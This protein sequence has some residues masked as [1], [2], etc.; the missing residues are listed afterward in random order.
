M[1]ILIAPDSFK[2]CMSALDAAHAMAV[3]AR[4]AGEALGVNIDIDI[5]PVSD[6]GEGFA[7]AL[8]HASEGELLTLE[9]AGPT[10]EPVE[11]RWGV[12]GARRISQPGGIADTVID[13]LSGIFMPVPFPLGRDDEHRQDAIMRPV[14][15]IEAAQV[16]GLH[17]VPIAEREPEWATTL[18][19]GELIAAALD[20][21][22]RRLII[23]LG[24]SATCDGG[25][26]MAAALGAV[27]RDEQSKM[28][29][30]PTGAHLN[31]IAEIDVRRLD[32][33]L[34]E[35]EIIAAC[36]VRNPL[37]GP[38]GA[39]PVYAPQ[40]GADPAQVARLN[41]GLA[42]LARR[43]GETG[44]PSDSAF[45]GAGAAGGLGFGVVSF[46]GA[47]KGAGAEIAIHLLGLRDRA[48][49]AS[50]VLTGEGRL[51]AQS[52]EGKAAI[53][54]AREARQAGTDA[55]ALVGALG[56]GAERAEAAAGGPFTRIIPISPP[57]MPTEEAIR[58]AP[59]LLTAASEVVVRQWLEARSGV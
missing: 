45:E 6:G 53:E 48:K 16:V 5:C 1:R 32:P 40:K 39:A 43:C 37:T 56:E 42:N 14:A 9:A 41:D 36:D 21:G 54:V 50:L 57:D 30:A 29:E 26:G 44:L 4:D 35:T 52:L 15:I 23:G 17:L 28:I 20:A 49:K 13:A 11:A 59:E 31:D 2:E 24:G 33:R 47:M 12:L 58:R 38:D 34:S 10:G 27:F 8:V 25:V 46:L 3:G 18:G 55:I 7:S 22:H 19:L 51:D